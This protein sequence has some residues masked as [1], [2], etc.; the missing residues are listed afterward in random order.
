MFY[1]VKVID[2]MEEI[3]QALD[4][5]RILNPGKLCFTRTTRLILTSL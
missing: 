4:P 5:Q 2:C 1:L 3:K